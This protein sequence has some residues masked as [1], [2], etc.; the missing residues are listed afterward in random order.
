MTDVAHMFDLGAKHLAMGDIPWKAATATISMALYT[1]SKSINQTTDETYNS[2][3]ELAGSAGYTQTGVAM[4]ISDPTIVGTDPS[5]YTKLTGSDVTWATATF[6][7]VRTA[8]IYNNT[9]SKYLAGY[10]TWG[11]DKAAQGGNFTV[12]APATGWFN[13][14]TP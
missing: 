6:T 5:V 13:L 12:Q 14:A 2:T 9:G 1:S 3:N 4:T 7:G 8:E 11:A 10:I